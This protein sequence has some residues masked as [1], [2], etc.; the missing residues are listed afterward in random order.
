[1]DSVSHQQ[2][3]GHLRDFIAD[4]HPMAAPSAEAY[5]FANVANSNVRS[6]LEE[7]LLNPTIEMRQRPS[8]EFR[9]AIVNIGA[10]LATL[11][12][13]QIAASDELR[14]CAE[15][16]EQLH[17]GSLI[18]DDIQDGSPV[19]RN[20]PSLH[21]RLGIPHALSIGNWLYFR[22]LRSLE[23]LDLEPIRRQLLN[24]EWH[25]AMELAHFGQVMDL[26]VS[27]EQVP[28]NKLV[29]VCYHCALYKT[30]SITALAIGMGALVQGASPQRIRDI[31]KL[32][33]ALGVYLQQLNDIG[34]ITG[35]F[36]NEKRFEDLLSLKPS[37]V[38]GLTLAQMGSA[39]FER[40]IL[41]ARALPHT[42]LMDEWIDANALQSTAEQHAE[43]LFQI[44][45]DAFQEAYPAADL[46]RLKQ[47]KDRIKS[48]YA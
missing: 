44:A 34:N 31:K 12:F 30:G 40:L 22:A 47:L 3:M 39:S 28:R 11:P 33:A 10:E 6:L 15:A 8:H 1:M 18:V 9:S 25:E 5:A 7:L 19:R 17:L 29:D 13:G 42:Q 41:A 46:T 38:W 45:L 43:K 26:S 24:E 48:A 21:T 2:V 35:D 20:G 16:I 14:L 4:S 37:F 27:M 36:D 23:K 32:G